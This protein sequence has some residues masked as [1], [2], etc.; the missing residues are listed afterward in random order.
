MSDLTW[1]R[2]ARFG[3]FIHWG[4]YAVPAG[5]WK[6]KQIKGIGEQIMR[7]AQIPNREY[8]K[9]AGQFNPVKF[10][11]DAWVKLAVDAGMKYLVITAKHHDGFAMFESDVD[12]YNIVKATP[13]GKDVV[14]ALAE[15]CAMHGIKF[16]V[17]YS[18]R[19]DWHHP[20]GAWSEWPEQYDKPIEE[21]GFDF[22][23]CLE[24]KCIPQV[25]ELLTEYG[26]I[27]L[28]WYDTPADS[29]PA[30]SR[31]LVDV[32]HELQPQCLVC[33]RVGN[34]CGDYDV[35]GDNEFPYGSKNMDGEVPATLNHTWGFKSWDH[36]WKSVEQLLYSLIRS[37]SN[38]CN[39]LLN[40][41]P[42]AEGIVPEESVER[43]KIIGEWMKVNGEAIYGA[44]AGPFP[45]PFPW[46]MMTV[47]DSNL[48]L[49]F[50]E[51]TGS[52]FQLNGLKSRCKKAVVLADPERGIDVSQEY[53]AETEMDKLI[54]NGL[55][56][57]APD[58]YF[59]V[60]RLELDGA[61]EASSEQLQ[62]ADGTV[63]LLASEAGLH[64]Q[65]DSGLEIDRKGLPVCFH[66]NSGFMEW[67]F[68]LFKP[69]KYR[70]EALTNRHWSKS[71]L[72]GVRVKVQA[73]V[74]TFELELQEDEAVQN[75][76]AKYHPETISFIGEAEYDAPGEYEMTLEVAAMPGYEVS[77]P[78][79]EDLGDRDMRTLNLIQIKLVPKN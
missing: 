48:Y 42:T 20:D 41:G 2:E 38:G 22:N 11:A 14:K 52:T 37:A 47:K 6:G 24:E 4:L 27:G 45:Y 77:N 10:D 67:K 33:N 16:C 60:I 31:K 9:L 53:N 76:Q 55:P 7:F 26:P 46:G 12:D 25:K 8:E 43:L 54:L 49:I 36:E 3:L 19:Q 72:E 57:D 30:Q 29:T 59:S 21:R 18:Q 61:P 34:D 51:W 75:I 5:V 69:G 78:L 74:K 65:G 66:E 64:A 79:S 62:A 63:T 23:R 70:I 32:V 13:Y 39:Y 68:R 40:I 44:G 15:A 58:K 17:Y 50:S 1:W 56:K 73:G 28:V 71:W 35:L